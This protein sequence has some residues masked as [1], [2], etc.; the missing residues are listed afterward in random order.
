MESVG[1]DYTAR[2]AETPDREGMA[3]MEGRG[4]RADSCGVR[5]V[6]HRSPPSSDTDFC[7]TSMLL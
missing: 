3:D 4:G 7:R 2:K 6:A 5:G 1:K